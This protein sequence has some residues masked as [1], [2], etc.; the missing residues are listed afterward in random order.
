MR[1]AL[2]LDTFAT[3]KVAS[4]PL[5]ATL[6]RNYINV[7]GFELFVGVVNLLEIFSWPR[8]WPE[9]LNFL[10]SVPF[11]IA[12]SP[13]DV[14]SAEV[15]RYPD[16]ILESPVAFRSTDHSL[17]QME[18]REVLAAMLKGEVARYH[19]DWFKGAYGPILKSILDKRSS[20]L[21]DKGGKYSQ[22]ELRIFLDFNVMR[23]LYLDHKEFLQSRIKA[24]EVVKLDLFKSVHMPILAIFLEYYVQKKNGK[25]SDIGDIHQLG[26]VPYAELSVLDNERHSL[27]QRINRER[28]F[29]Q[30][31]STCNLAEFTAT[32]RNAGNATMAPNQGPQAGT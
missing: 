17:S 32:I 1:K 30:T 21:P 12:S 5:L 6:A 19:K 26:L 8:R 9:V 31:L 28:L 27:V 25:A 15:L 16:P 13:E 10:S 11:S 14:T 4:D 2:Y 23:V 22:T 29:P 18:L 7:V 3:V 24:G 20:Y